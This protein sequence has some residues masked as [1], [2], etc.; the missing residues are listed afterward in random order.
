M[1]PLESGIPSDHYSQ[2]QDEVKRALFQKKSGIILDSGPKSSFAE[3]L[4]YLEKQKK[5][6]G[7][8]KRELKQTQKQ[9]MLD[10]KKYKS[11]VEAVESGA[12]G[13]HKSR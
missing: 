11:D 1:H 2:Q 3:K 10:K 13:Q 12:S 7:A 9:L 5:Q 4:E 6:L 8:M